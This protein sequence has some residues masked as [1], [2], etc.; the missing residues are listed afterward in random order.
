M[1][2]SPSASAARGKLLPWII[3][4]IAGVPW[5]YTFILTITALTNG[6]HPF[7]I[8]YWQTITGVVLLIGLNLIR[9]KPLLPFDRFHIVFY[10]VCGLLGTS[11]PGV[12]YLYAAEHLQAGVLA[13]AL[14]TVPMMTFG[15][16]CALKLEAYATLRMIGLGLGCGAILMLTVPETGL[17]DPE[18]WPWVI[19][20]IG[21]ACC[22]AL[23][24]VFLGKYLP[25]HDDPFLILTG[26]MLA[27]VILL[28]PIV[29]VSGTFFL[30]NWPLD[31]VGWSVFGMAAINVMSYGLFILLIRLSG[32]VF[33]SQ[34]GYVVTIAG[35][36]W[37][38]AIFGESHS[39]W[40]WGALA[41]M[42]AGLTFVRPRKDDEV[43][44]IAHP[45]DHI[46][47]QV[48]PDDA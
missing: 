35:V 14:A 28:T 41:A 46:V 25:E 38:I 47:D 19:V 17:P 13:I 30:P 4:M 48:P 10:L 11:L 16:A 1:K 27:G 34:M 37:G 40:F 22:Y 21:A 43:V 6:D 45:G 20:A 8:A 31:T 15:L 39:L 7:A 24:N 2:T 44:A 5:G 12:L 36:A 26:M 9:R 3:L 29:F 23:E 42:L 18:A 32:P 33:A